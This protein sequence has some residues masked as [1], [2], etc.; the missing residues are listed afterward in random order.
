MLKTQKNTFNCYYFVQVQI[1]L[2]FPARTVDYNYQVFSCSFLFSLCVSLSPS[3]SSMLL[4][5]KH[6]IVQFGRSSTTFAK[7]W[8]IQPFYRL[9]EHCCEVKSKINTICAPLKKVDFSLE[10]QMCPNV[11]SWSYKRRVYISV[12]CIIDALG[13]IPQYII[14]EWR[15][16][17]EVHYLQASVYAA[18]L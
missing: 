17:R 3:L 1:D 7:T 9:D 2:C 14:W 8:W 5:N 15:K 4:S 6:H 12:C 16:P 11:D 10:T 13:L 18:L